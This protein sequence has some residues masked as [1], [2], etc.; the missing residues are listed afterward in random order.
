MT[1][2]I[3]KEKNKQWLDFVCVC[4]RGEPLNK[5]YDIVIGNVAND[6]VFKTVD[7]FVLTYVGGNK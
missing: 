6:D 1:Y 7:M 2:F 5:E 4:R 3:R